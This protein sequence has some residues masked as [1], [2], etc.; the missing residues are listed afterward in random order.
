MIP[1]NPIVHDDKGDV[2]FCR[3]GRNAREGE[4]VLCEEC[5]TWQ[6]IV[7]Y[8]PNEV[9]PAVHFCEN[10]RSKYLDARR[11]AKRQ[12]LAPQSASLNCNVSNAMKAQSSD[13]S[14]AQTISN[15][16]QGATGLD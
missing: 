6:H 4:M 14:V 11:D 10:C 15:R 2:T 5:D 7:C 13:R 9:V 16:R 12:R 8:Y 1:S 3:C